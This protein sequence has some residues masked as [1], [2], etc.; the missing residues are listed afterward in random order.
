[1]K[2]EFKVMRCTFVGPRGR[3]RSRIQKD[4][5]IG[6]FET[7]EE[8]CEAEIRLNCDRL[9]RK[10]PGYVELPLGYID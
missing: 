6:V 2:A 5:V 3:S 8:A 9:G 1:M 4:I 7:H 10:F